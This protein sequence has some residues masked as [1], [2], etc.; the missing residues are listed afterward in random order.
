M[1][2]PVPG[3]PDPAVD[4]GMVRQHLERVLASREFAGSPRMVAFLRFVTEFALTN[5]AD[6]LKEY[7]IAVEVY[8]HKPDYDPQAKSTVRVEATRLR[9]RLRDYYASSGQGDPIRI[10]MP[11]GTY[12]PVFRM[13]QRDAISTQND[14]RPA[15]AAPPESDVPREPGPGRNRSP[16]WITVAII[17]VAGLVAAVLFFR[18]RPP[19]PSTSV[20]A[21]AVL[22]FVSLAASPEDERLCDGVTEAVTSA[23]GRTPG[24]QVPSRTA[25]A[26][27][28][29]KTVDVRK[30]AA[31]HRV[32]A[33]LEGSLRREGNRYLLTA[34]LIDTQDGYH[35]WAETFDRTTES[36]LDFQQQVAGEIANALVERVSGRV[37]WRQ[38]GRPGG[39]SEARSLHLKAH[40][41]LRQNRRQQS[42]PKGIP[43]HFIEA[44]RLLE[45]ATE[46]E[47]DF[48]PAWS[49]LAHALLLSS[50]M[51][52]AERQAMLDRAKSAAK[53]AIQAD[54]SFAEPYMVLGD[55][56][57]YVDWD[58]PAAEAVLRRAIELNP[59]DAYAQS[60]YA[61]VLRITGRF[62][63][64]KI[65]LARALT[66]APD[67]ASL[68]VQNALHLYDE[69]RCAEVI[70]EADQALTIRPKLTM[71]LWIKGLCYE[72]QR[73]W[74]AAEREFKAALA[75]APEDGRALPALGHL[76]A[77]SGKHAGASRILAQLEALQSAGKRVTYSI[78]LIYTGLGQRDQAFAW[79]YR[80]FEERDQ[81]LPYAG[82]EQRL[83]P[84]R[85]DR[86]WNALLSKLRL[87]QR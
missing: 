32:N 80:A 19:K 21:I 82:I 31:D 38:A 47:P 50:E 58:F 17:A 3:V 8:G 44:I 74:S 83:I 49:G 30:L 27:L 54:P 66:L 22:P 9:N 26:N 16:W 87:K 6:E 33:F 42:W 25:L 75:I 55:I 40:D 81:S 4:E 1:A 71:A 11:K 65:E 56:A 15:Q 85:E 86:R 57:L 68:R 69:R 24:L 46:L 77:V 62:T 73:E 60:E 59:R 20:S 72:A 76:Y 51:D 48:A 45:R 36:A 10:E 64:A 53:R 29:G 7:L 23:L 5:R 52:R 63:Q 43:P 18:A 35:L 61:D 41:L 70:R 79:L 37:P 67:D 14:V 84:L 12:V 39:S 28:K 34:Q 2:E 13:A 78:A